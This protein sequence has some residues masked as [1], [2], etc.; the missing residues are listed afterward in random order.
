MNSEM[1]SDSN[2]MQKKGKVETR[3]QAKVN[4]D[5]KVLLAHTRPETRKLPSLVTKPS[6]NSYHKTYVC[7]T[8]MS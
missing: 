8:Y 3:M 4:R 1:Y 2:K 7:L 5:I 6:D